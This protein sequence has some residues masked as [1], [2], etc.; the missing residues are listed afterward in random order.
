[1]TTERRRSARIEI[2]GRLHG[3]S[4][5]LDVPVGIREMSLKG[6]AVETDLPL[7]EG[8]IHEF[9]LTLGDES[10]VEL[11]G[12]VLRCRNVAEIDEAPRYVSGVEFID[13]EETTDGVGGL[14]DRIR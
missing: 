14:I 9:R 8:A 13:A 3:H 10:T 6:M 1:M 7:P 2:L 12:R 11:Q 4:V 5:S